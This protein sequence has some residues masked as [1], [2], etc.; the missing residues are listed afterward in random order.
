MPS[1][2]RVILI[3]N[4]TRDIELRSTSSGTSVCDMGLAINNRIKRNDEWVDD[5]AYVDVT[6]FGRLAEIAAE[7]LSKG[8]PVFLE[9]RLQYET[10]EKDGQKKSR[11]KV[12]GER[13]QLIGG[14]RKQAAQDAPE[15]TRKE[16][17]P[18]RPLDQDEDGDIPF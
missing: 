14:D 10:W 1:Y 9:G 16:R 2:N 15:P 12:V 11:L 13:L 3:G 4:L 7:Y 18:V 6:L 17:P 5:V 8:S